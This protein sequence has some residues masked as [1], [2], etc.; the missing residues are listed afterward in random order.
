MHKRSFI[1][2]ALVATAI[3]FVVWAC[4]KT[5]KESIASEQP[6]IH[7]IAP[8]VPP[9]IIIK[10]EV[11]EELERHVLFSYIRKY[12]NK[13]STKDM[14]EIYTTIKDSHLK[15]LIMGVIRR[16][17]AFTK[18][19]FSKKRNG[20]PLAVGLMGVNLCN[21][22]ELKEAGIIKSYLD[23]YKVKENIKAGE[24]LLKQYLVISEGDVITA[25][26]IYWIGPENYRLPKY[27]DAAYPEDVLASVGHIRIKM[28]IAVSTK[29][30]ELALPD[31]S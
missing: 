31:E 1:I 3:L 25:L 13:V 22:K 24:Y 27:R 4:V 21:V 8:I 23:L 10:K 2:G 19:A 11:D 20:T 26:K 15:Y 16:E 12:N 18:V 7:T 9:E 29:N 28:E 6:I 14:E 5:E 17:S 30:K